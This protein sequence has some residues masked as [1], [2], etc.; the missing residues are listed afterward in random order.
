MVEK[1]WSLA[2]KMILNPSQFA[3]SIELHFH[4]LCALTDSSFVEVAVNY[5]VFCP[6][7]LKLQK[8]SYSFLPSGS[9]SLSPK[10]VARSVVLRAHALVLPFKLTCQLIPSEGFWGKVHCQGWMGLKIVKI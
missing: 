2:F 7:F 8:S 3:S 5:S 10:A 9:A 1:H 4:A 6:R